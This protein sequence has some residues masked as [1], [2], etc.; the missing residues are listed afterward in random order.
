MKFLKTSLPKE[1][2]SYGQAAHSFFVIILSKK[3]G[4]PLFIDDSG[5]LFF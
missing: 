2:E 5:S 3:V 1:I 4:L